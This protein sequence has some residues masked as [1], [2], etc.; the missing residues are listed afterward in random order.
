[1]DFDDS[2]ELRRRFGE[3]E[4]IGEGT[5]MREEN[6]EVLFPFQWLPAKIRRWEFDSP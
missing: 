6:W 5:R 1:M 2:G 4:I 3:G